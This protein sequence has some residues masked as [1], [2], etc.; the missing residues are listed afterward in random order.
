MFYVLYHQ[1]YNLYNFGRIFKVVVAE[2]LRFEKCKF[3]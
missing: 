3:W 1:F 2:L